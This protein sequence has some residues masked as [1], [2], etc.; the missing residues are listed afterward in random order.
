[1]RP[2]TQRLLVIAL[3]I[4]A[5]MPLLAQESQ[6]DA[7]PERP[8]PPKTL[9]L[10]RRKIKDLRTRAAAGAAIA[11]LRGSQREDGLWSGGTLHAMCRVDGCTAGKHSRFEIGVTGLATLALLGTGSTHED[12][13]HAEAVAD[14]LRALIAAQ[15]AQGCF[16]SR[17]VAHCP[18]NHA[19]AT[20]AVAEAYWLSRDPELRP[21]VENARDFALACHL[22]R[23]QTLE[24]YKLGWRYAGVRGDCD[25]SATAYLLIALATTRLSGVPVD[26]KVFD[27]ADEWYSRMRTLDPPGRIGYTRRGGP[28]ARFGHDYHA[29]TTD[30]PANML[31]G[32]AERY[33]TKFSRS[34][35][36]TSLLAWT[37]SLG[38]PQ[39]VR[40][41]AKELDGALPP[42]PSEAGYVDLHTALYGLV[43]LAQ[44]RPNGKWTKAVRTALI[45]T[46]IA[47]GDHAGSWPPE[48]DPW[49]EAGGRVYVTA[50]GALAIQAPTRLP[51]LWHLRRARKK[52]GN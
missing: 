25:S 31:A 39:A 18:Y 19:L 44:H 40:W 4:G 36:A 21:A 35:T 48:I 41:M 15:D 16:G 14:A 1:M 29:F 3:A 5:A 38:D 8:D 50:M 24:D 11:W 47:D 49:G 37:L 22:S 30:E 32:V 33:P 26:D 28:D 20:M 42:T 9:E 13:E 7:A 27:R 10:R 51:K 12:G 34:S 52:K 6:P 2:C 46:Q 43:V 45:E 17:T 23:V